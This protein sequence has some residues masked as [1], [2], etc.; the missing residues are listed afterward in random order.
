MGNA[1][2]HP[3]LLPQ[4]DPDLIT[5]NAK[6]DIEA[7]KYE[8]EQKTFKLNDEEREIVGI[9]DI[10]PMGFK[11]WRDQAVGVEGQLPLQQAQADH[12]FAWQRLNGVTR[13]LIT[14]LQDIPEQ[15]GQFVGVIENNH[16][17]LEDRTIQQVIQQEQLFVVDLA[18]FVVDGELVYTPVDLPLW[19]EARMWFNMMEAHYHESITHFGFTHVLMDGVSVCMHQMLSERHPIYKLLHPHFHYMHYI[20]NI[21]LRTLVEP[22]GFVDADMFFNRVH[23][24]SLIARENI[25]RTYDFEANIQA[26]IE[27]REVQN[28]P[29]YFFRDYA[30]M[31]RGAIQTFVTNYTTHYY[32]NDE[33]V[34]ND[35]EIQEYRQKLILARNAN[36]NVGGCGMQ[37]IPQFDGI[38]HLV[39]FLT[40]IIYI[41]S[42]EHSATNFPQYEQYAFPPNFPGILHIV[43]EASLDDIIP[44]KQE[45]LSTVKIMKLLTLRLTK[46]LGNYEKKYLDAMD[47]AGRGFVDAFKDTLDN[48]TTDMRALNDGIVTNN[49]QNPNQVQEYPYEWLLPH[50][51]LNSISI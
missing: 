29:G 5:R 12:W 16:P 33:N 48:I 17:Y 22:G 23:M 13:N 36:Q 38:Q 44:T 15:F 2:N 3:V 39:E 7:A 24:L 20:N 28:I 11:V 8:L 31:I 43:P 25:N 4:N 40:N 51:V 37:G 19:V 21:A 27:E 41:C 42:V 26:S 9:E 32:E 14:R 46:S 49:I 1:H 18:N 10:P 30:L 47:E 34:V 45:M 6:R 50:N 35:W